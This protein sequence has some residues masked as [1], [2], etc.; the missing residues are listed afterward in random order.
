MSSTGRCFLYTSP[1]RLCLY[2]PCGTFR[3]LLLLLDFLS[4]CLFELVTLT[5]VFM[6]WCRKL[7]FEIACLR[8]FHDMFI[9]TLS[10]WKRDGSC[11][12]FEI[13]CL[14]IFH[15]M[16]FRPPFHWKRAG[17]C[18]KLV[19]HLFCKWRSKYQSWQKRIWRLLP[20]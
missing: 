10:C 15:E 16:F 13:A 14:R 9:R 20:V 4:S 5:I 7:R 19:A 1:G 8:T 17:S 11:F 18:F 2:R 12:R 6:S 3:A